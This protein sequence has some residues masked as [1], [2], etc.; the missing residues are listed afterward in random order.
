MPGY[1]SET[2]FVGKLSF[3]IIMWIVILFI[4]FYCI[5]R[6]PTDYDT[7][8]RKRYRT[9][10]G[11][12]CILGAIGLMFINQKNVLL[13]NYYLSTFGTFTPNETMIQYGMGPNVPMR[14]AGVEAVFALPTFEQWLILIKIK[15]FSVWMGFG[16][17]F[18]FFKKSSTRPVAKV[19]K[20]FG[21]LFLLF[22]VP[23]TL[24][25]HH[26][27]DWEEFLFTGVA[28]LM[29]WLL[30]RTY[31]KDA[32]VPTLPEESKQHS[33]NKDFAPIEPEE[34]IAIS[35]EDNYKGSQTDNEQRLHVCSNNRKSC[36]DKSKLVILLLSVFSSLC[37]LLSIV[38]TSIYCY[39]KEHCDRYLYSSKYDLWYLRNCDWE[40]KR[41]YDVDHKL[42][43]PIVEDYS[44][45]LERYGRINRNGYYT[46]WTNA[47]PPQYYRLLS[48][49]IDDSTSYISDQIKRLEKDGCCFEINISMKNN[50]TNQQLVFYDRIKDNFEY[51]HNGLILQSEYW[52]RKHIVEVRR[53]KAYEFIAYV[54]DLAIYDD[55][56]ESDYYLLD[57]PQ[58]VWHIKMWK[59]ITWLFI[60]CTILF[61]ITLLSY[62]IYTKQR[63]QIKNKRAFS[64]LMYQLIC[65]IL[66]CFMY[67]IY[68][69]GVG[70]IYENTIIYAIFLLSF[71]L[72]LIIYT[73]RKIK[74]E[75]GSYSLFPQWLENTINHFA[76]SESPMRAMLVFVIFPLFY[77]CTLPC[78]IFA[79][80]YL[81]PAIVLY[82]LVF[83]II[84]IIKGIAIP[85]NKNSM[86]K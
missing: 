39:S 80:I 18:L 65:L 56:Y 69:F 79:L 33:E 36:Y 15:S 26:F 57:S 24:A 27:F 19:R 52:Y 48:Y 37:M 67:V 30:L 83:F 21:Y 60:I 64:A 75:S 66:E 32:I 8:Y 47:S 28:I 53:G 40:M 17:M 55:S 6:N 49:N 34:E 70:F 77:I 12:L 7:N 82:I 73:F 54:P 63:L 46:G 62:M 3:D 86:E 5:R 84:W 61:L 16:I 58:K 20:A 23:A 74:C 78:G 25:S 1:L 81:I 38:F 9:I 68:T 71:R 50:K 42:G 72:P 4:T 51:L 13:P 41:Y 45:Y 22:L 85:V 43:K 11:V 35:V 31:R 10:M 76:T 44:L 2:A 29:A 59:T 14:E